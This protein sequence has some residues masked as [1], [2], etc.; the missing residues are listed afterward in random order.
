MN[1]LSWIEERIHADGSA[2]GETSKQ[3]DV[4]CGRA[5]AASMI[6]LA[7]QNLRAS[8]R[9]GMYD[10]VYLQDLTDGFAQNWSSFSEGAD[11]RD[12]NPGRQI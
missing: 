12:F 5:I 2:Q 3:I 9:L 1:V 6:S 11:P 10:S 7:K 4:Q 8:S